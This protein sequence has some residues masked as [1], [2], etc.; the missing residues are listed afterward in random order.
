MTSSNEQTLSGAPFIPLSNVPPNCSKYPIF[1][2]GYTGGVARHIFPASIIFTPW[3]TSAGQ[4]KETWA[5]QQPKR[6]V[7]FLIQSAIL[8]DLPRIFPEANFMAT[9]ESFGSGDLCARIVRWARSELGQASLQRLKRPP[10]SA[11]ALASSRLSQE[12][13]LQLCR[14]HCS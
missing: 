11:R 6:V 1:H 5:A 10:S 7:D 8:P 14:V 3:S 9:A 13:V 12:P 4:A 2:S